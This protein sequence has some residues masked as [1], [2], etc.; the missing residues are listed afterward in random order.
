[1]TVKRRPTCGVL[2]GVAFAPERRQR[3]DMREQALEPHS[4]NRADVLPVV[5][6]QNSD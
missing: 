4:L 2:L 6:D 3:G 5:S 1:M